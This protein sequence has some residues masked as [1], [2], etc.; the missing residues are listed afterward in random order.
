[1]S[2]SVHFNPGT[3]KN[4][5]PGLQ[6]HQER[7]TQ[8]EGEIVNRTTNSYIDTSQ[9]KYNKL[10]YRNPDFEKNYNGSVKAK[11]SSQ[12]KELNSKLQ[13]NGRRAK[14][15][16]ANLWMAGTLQLSKD[17]LDRLGYAE[18]KKWDEQDHEVQKN[19]QVVYMNLALGM[20]DRKEH[21]GILETATLHVDES[22]PHVDFIS[23][24]IDLDDLDYSIGTVLNGRGKKHRKGQKL[25]EIQDELENIALEKFGKTLVEKYDF[26]RGEPASQTKTLKTSLKERER[27]INER[28]ENIKLREEKL[29]KRLRIDSRRSRELDEREREVNDADERITMAIESLTKRELKLNSVY[30][31]R[32]QTLKDFASE[33]IDNEELNIIQY[34]QETD[35]M[36][37]YWELRRK[38]NEVAHKDIE[39]DNRISD[40][41]LKRAINTSSFRESQTTGNELEF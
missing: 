26:H 41:M 33:R 8:K 14:R 4:L 9:T 27:R 12:F 39:R 25:K 36:D 17:T 30:K 32:L 13:E 37:K 3:L 40:E 10:L 18:G 16:N 20:A 1:M 7:F 19:I 11:L 2:I 23:T 21:F 28:E 34:I 6:K 24:G 5:K 29:E 31:Q 38:A 15:S 22:I 35:G